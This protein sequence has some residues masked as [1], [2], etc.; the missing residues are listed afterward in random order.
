[1][2]RNLAIIIG[3]FM[4][5]VMFGQDLTVDEAMSAMKEL[6]TKYLKGEFTKIDAT[7]IDQYVDVTVTK[8][9]SFSDYSYGNLMHEFVEYINTRPAGLGNYDLNAENIRKIDYVKENQTKIAAYSAIVDYDG[10]TKFGETVK[11]SSLF[12]FNWKGEP[13]AARPVAYDRNE[14]RAKLAVWMEKKVIRDLSDMQDPLFK[15]E[16]W[17]S[18][19]A[20]A[21]G[22]GN[23]YEMKYCFILDRGENESGLSGP[24][25]AY[26]YQIQTSSS[27]IKSVTLITGRFTENDGIISFDYKKSSVS[28]YNVISDYSRSFQI[29]D[30]S[31]INTKELEISIIGSTRATK[32]VRN[33]SSTPVVFEYTDPSHL[34]MTMPFYDQAINFTKE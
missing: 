28:L 33:S 26:Y 12:F 24:F 22:N 13:I 34:R 11:M 1:M 6:S 2:K 16:K 29:G 19:T 21:T 10:L 31:S 9:Y 15:K 5:V 27:Q 25:K 3:L 30:F 17:I 7:G 20:Y 14:Y 23:Q 32:M 18:E 4:S 8:V